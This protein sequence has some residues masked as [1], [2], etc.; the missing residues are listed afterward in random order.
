MVTTYSSR[1]VSTSKYDLLH[2]GSEV[3]DLS[4]LAARTAAALRRVSVTGQPSEA[5]AQVVHAMAHLLGE[6]AEAMQFFDSGGRE[7]SP[8]SG[9]LAA[10]V[11]AAIDAV[12]EERLEPE[13]QTALSQR[14][15][16]LAARLDPSAEQL[17]PAE[18]TN[19][20]DYFSGLASA[21][22]DQAGHVGEITTTL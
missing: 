21:V 16:R 17:T 15:S 19:L 13:E 4:L 3:V 10:R 1:G 22:L 2:G 11:D 14:L 7:G 8:P 20:A 5:D 9:A 18:A 12:L 6:A